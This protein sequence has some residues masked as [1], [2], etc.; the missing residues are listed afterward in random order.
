MAKWISTHP[1][2]CVDYRLNTSQ[3]THYT[4]WHTKSHRNQTIVL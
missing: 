4:E 1:H 3:K 2:A